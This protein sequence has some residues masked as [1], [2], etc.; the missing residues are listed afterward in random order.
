MQPEL[1]RLAVV[2]LASAALVGGCGE[3]DANDATPGT[4]TTAVEVTPQANAAYERGF[5]DCSS[6]TL[7][8]LAAK[9]KVKQNVSAVA[10]AVGDAWANELGG[11]EST[12]AYGEAGC[13]E[14]F[15]TRTGAA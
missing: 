6:V 13:K 2:L 12:A 7:K 15:K 11:G 4:T 3:D 1:R 8:R 9:Y 10:Q 5:S 14:A